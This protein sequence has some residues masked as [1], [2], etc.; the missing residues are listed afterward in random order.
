MSSSSSTQTLR[1][2]DDLIK[3][4]ASLT[5]MSQR[6]VKEQVKTLDVPAFNFQG[7][8]LVP[9]DVVDP[10][11]DRWA[12]DIKA[13][14]HQGG[15]VAISS[16]NGSVTP[17]EV[18]DT[19]AEP[20]PKA[21][22]KSKKTAKAEQNG[23]AAAKPAAKSAAKP[24]PQPEAEANPEP[25]PEAKP[26]AEPEVKVESKPESKPEAKTKAPAPKTETKLSEL[27]LPKG[28]SQQVSN[29]YG[30]TLDKLLPEDFE[31][32]LV[33]LKEI[34]DESSLG[35]NYLNRIAT[36]I[37]RKY[38]GRTARSTAYRGLLGKAQDM[39][40][41]LKAGDAIMSQLEKET[42]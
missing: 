33:Y 40:E 13:K 34:T 12:A 14:L 31:D 2:L 35:S 15:T 8:V 10:L 6:Q 42:A 41:N 36:V 18:T 38:K 5:G 17:V 11:V 28:F 29:R 30:P 32:R 9:S 37:Q 20:T 7:I 4:I 1:Q 24:E 23:A 39:L 16:A 25:Q 21:A 22:S 27:K 19:V 3:D 26:E